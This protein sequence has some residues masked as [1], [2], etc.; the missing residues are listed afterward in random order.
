MKV[1]V[2]LIVIGA[3]GTIPKGLAKGSEAL[4]IWWQVETIVE[5]GQNTEKSPGDLR[6]RNN[7]PNNRIASVDYVVLEIKQL[8]L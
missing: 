7:N 4:E 5:I 6:K 8:I 2:I 3:L 1:T